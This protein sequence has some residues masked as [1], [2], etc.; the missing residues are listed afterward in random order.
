MKTLDDIAIT[1]SQDTF[2]MQKSI[3]FVCILVRGK[4]YIEAVAHFFD[5]IINSKGFNAKIK[6]WLGT[7][8]EKVW[9]QQLVL[10]IA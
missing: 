3:I 8:N 5:G 10:G 7:L 2:L 6:E 9:S 1:F 4:K